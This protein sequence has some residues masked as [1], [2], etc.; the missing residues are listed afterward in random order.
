MLELPIEA[1]ALNIQDGTRVDIILETPT[2]PPHKR[3]SAAGKYKG[4]I[5]SSEEFI[6][7]KQQEIDLEDGIRE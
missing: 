5:S 2:L 4:L 1:R 6:R 3:V 7:R